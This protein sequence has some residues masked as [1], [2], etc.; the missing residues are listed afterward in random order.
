[1]IALV[2]VN[3]ETV[4]LYGKDGMV[5][6]PFSQINSLSDYI[7]NETIYY[8]TNA[9]EVDMIDVVNL[10]NQIKGT[11]IIVEE[12]NEDSQNL[13]LCSTLQ[14]TIYIGEDI[15]FEGRYDFKAY[16]EEMKETIQ[17]NPTLEMLL[18]QGKI[19]IIG[20][21][22]KRQLMKGQKLEKQQKL[23]KMKDKD[24]KIGELI[25]DRSVDDF[26]ANPGADGSVLIDMTNDNPDV[27]VLTETE[28]HLRDLGIK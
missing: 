20:E 24:D 7:I 15:R 4:D 17:N 26:I 27:P 28:K 3:N 14:E 8:I 19:R 5:E 23:Q 12:V 10:V 11:D 1:M 9:K 22:V 16:D 2:N 6:V 21:R 18:K 13:Y 25:I